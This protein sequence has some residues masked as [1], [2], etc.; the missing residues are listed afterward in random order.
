MYASPAT[1]PDF[2]PYK[3]SSTPQH[4][5]GMRFVDGEDMYRY[6]KAGASNISR[7]KVQ[8]AAAPKTNHHNIAWASGG[9]LGATTVTFTLGNTAAVANEYA[10]GWLVINDATGEGTKYRIKSHPAAA[11]L[12]TLEVTL[13]SPIRNVALVSGSEASLVH[14]TYNGVVEGTT[15]TRRAAGVP[16]TSVTAGDYCWLMTHGVCPVL[17]DTTTTLGAK[18]KVGAVAGAVTDMTDILGASAEV[19][20]GTADIMA[21]VDTEYRPITLTID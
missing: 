5:I 2:D 14:N 7:G 19:E 15:I 11:G 20:I 1:I 10:E 16:L 8:I 6:A 21:G 12:A 4:Q 13:F 3:T 18:Q 9:A 17:C